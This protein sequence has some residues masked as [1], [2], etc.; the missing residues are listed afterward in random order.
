VSPPPIGP[1][2]RPLDVPRIPDEYLVQLFGPAVTAALATLQA[3]MAKKGRGEES[4]LM[5]LLIAY[6]HGEMFRLDRPREV[7]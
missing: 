2:G 3:E 7:V 1:D 5:D 6:R 4:E